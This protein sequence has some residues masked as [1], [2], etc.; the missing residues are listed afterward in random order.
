MERCRKAPA[1]S[2]R[3]LAVVRKTRRVFRDHQRAPPSRTTVLVARFVTG[4]E[5]PV[6]SETSGLARLAPAVRTSAAI[7]ESAAPSSPTDG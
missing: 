1:L 3:G 7:A 6:S 4:G 2:T 5:P